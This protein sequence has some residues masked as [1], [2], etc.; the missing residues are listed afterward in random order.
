MTQVITYSNVRY[1][2]ISYKVLSY[3]RF[4]SRLKDGTF[5]ADEYQI[6]S[7][8][9]FN[10]SDVKR[11]INALVRN[12]HLLDLQNNRVRYIE[13]GVLWK[14]DDAY[15]KSLWVARAGRGTELGKRRAKDIDADDLDAPID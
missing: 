11:S 4:K 6:F 13:S 5:S 7:H 2:G 10:P 15:R 9:M 12:G 1:G 8:G 3:A 14:L